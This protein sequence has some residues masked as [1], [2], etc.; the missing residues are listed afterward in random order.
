MSPLVVATRSVPP[1]G[2]ASL[3]FR[4]RFRN[5]CCSL[6]ELPL[7]WRVFEHGS[8]RTCIFAVLNCVRVAPAFRWMILFTS[9]SANSLPLVREKFSS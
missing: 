2:M 9:T 1:P 7:M 5:T 3:A 4:N 6:P 8:D